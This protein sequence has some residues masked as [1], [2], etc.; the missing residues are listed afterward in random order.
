MVHI[1]FQQADVSVLQKAIDLDESLHGEI[2]E[3]KD[4]F[5]V[6]P[7]ANIYETEGYQA[8]RDWWKTLLE[9]SPYTD[10]LN[11]VNDK[12]A[13]HNLIN[14]LEDNPSLQAWIWV[15][16]NAHDVCG[17]YWLMSQLKD[18]AGRIEILFLNNLPFIDAN[19]AIFYPQALHE[20]LPKEFLKAKK[21]ARQI[22]KSEFE[23]DPDEW[24][25]L[26]DENATIR[27]LEGG[28]KIASKKEDFYDPLILQSITAEPQKLQRI[29]NHI[30][31][32]NN[33]RTGDVF[34]V[35]RIIEMIKI[36][37]LE[38]V[39]DWHKGWKDITI[40]LKEKDAK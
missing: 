4:D 17:Y 27:V 25:K 7:L 3:I 13:V 22:T 2:I 35:W 40:K 18:F 29:L 10:A 28:K 14:V 9:F 21:L 33:L 6:G 23:T 39:G 16:Q 31:S 8:R 30:F 32:K 34:V 5:A 24:E 38:S 20:I 15:A 1:V 26:C 36:N 11:I 19:G 37:R 12:L